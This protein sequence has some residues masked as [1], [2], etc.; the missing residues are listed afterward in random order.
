MRCATI[1]TLMLLFAGIIGV[2]HART[3]NA[4]TDEEGDGF[5][6]LFDG[7]TLNGWQGDVTH[8]AIEDGTLVC[9][10]KNIYTTKEYANFVLRFDF[11]LPPAGNNGIGIR[12][13]TE[14]K[15]SRVG[16]EIQILD[17]G[18]PKHK[19]I[20]AYQ[21]HGSIYGVVP[22]RRGFLKPAGHWNHEE[23]MAD[24][25]HVTVTLNGTMITDA[26]I[27]KIDETIDGQPHPGLH[28]SKGHIGLLGHGRSPD[29]VAF[30]DIRIKELP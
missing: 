6:S 27:S 21:S 5:V 20:Q 4:A 2:Q 28:D 25:S 9:H 3:A 16:M 12:T 11:K 8:Y 7:K 24:G 1:A 29:P 14:G 26:D 23:I 13:A 18:H 30:R 19:S 17:D 22:A 10:G 15:A